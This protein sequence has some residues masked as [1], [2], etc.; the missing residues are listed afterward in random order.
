MAL[1]FIPSYFNLLSSRHFEPDKATMLRSIVVMM[2]TAGV[3]YALDRAGSAPKAAAP[4]QQPSWW[5]R[6]LAFPMALPV[7]VFALVFLLA[8]LTSITPWVSLWGSYQRLQGTYTNLSYIA[9]AVMVVL[10]LRRREQL[11]RL[12]A[13]GVLGALPAVGYGLI[14]HS[15]HDPLPWRGDV[16]SRVAS[17]MGNSIFVAAYL[18]LILPLACYLALAGF[19]A[20]RRDSAS[21]RGGGAWGW[22][23]AYGLAIAGALLIA[24]ASICFGAVVRVP[25]LRYWWVYPGALLV[26]LALFVLPTLGI[27]RADRLRT[28]LVWPGIAAVGY[29]L[30]LG[31]MF[32]LGQGGGDQQVAASAGRGGTEWWIY[33]VLGVLFVLGSYALFYTLPR[34][35]ESSRVLSLMQ[36]VG[37]TA[38]AV[39]V[40]M[41]IIFTQSRGPWIG[42]M[43]GMFVFFTA[44]IV[45]AW[46]RARRENPARVALWRGLLVAEIAVTVLGGGFLV[47]FNLS[48]APIFEPLRT[49]P[50]IGRMGRLLETDEGTGL[51]RRLIWSGDEHAGGAVALITSDP[52]R[53]VIGWGPES[54]FVAYNRFYPP[55]LANIEARGASPDRSHEAYLDELVTKGV[56]GLASYLFV[57]ISVFTL[58]IALIRRVD[59]WHAQALVSACLSIIVAHCVEGLTGIPIVSSLMLFWIA[60]ATIVCV[61][62]LYGQVRFGAQ[63]EPEPAP[64]PAPAAKQQGG[65]SRRGAA[66]RGAAQRGPSQRRDE[67]AGLGWLIYTLVFAVGIAVVWF[68]NIDNVYADMRFQQ[69]QQYTE[70]S[71]AGL[72]QQIAGAEFYL[73]AIRMEPNQDFYYLSLGRTLMSIADIQRQ[74]SGTLGAVKQDAQL[75]DLL[76]AESAPAMLAQMQPLVAMSYAQAVL[77]QAYKINPLNKDHSANLGR[78]HAYWYS[79]MD[80]DPAQLDEALQWYQNSNAKAP[81]DVVILNEYAGTVAL[82]GSYSESKGD[83]AAAQQAY[84]QAEQLLTHSKELDQKYPDTDIRLADLLRIQGRTAEALDRYIA[85]IAS[86]PHAL[87]AEYNAVI[88]SVQDDKAQLGRLRDAYEQALAKTPDDATLTEIIGRIAVPQGDMARATS[89]FELL[90]NLEPQNPEAYR[91]LVVV[92]SDT[93]QYSRAADQAASWAKMLQAQGDTQQAQQIQG[94]ESYFR[95]LAGG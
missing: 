57:L 55:A 59:D 71:N 86:S 75:R 73:D 95:N 26:C 67:S 85:I 87:D 64:E 17:T 33:L 12:L 83:A 35:G 28:S 9:L 61:G 29:A 77:D 69:G 32:M 38:V 51:V 66:Q 22:A 80:Q 79:R 18:I 50:Y 48:N 92:L 44:L 62:L 76:Q 81:Q 11:E 70:G 30:W 19:R 39:L 94:L 4:P 46:G 54:M 34:L 72:Q 14:Q 74:T 78:L 25:D 56:L 23:A 43:A 91:N 3:V 45:I 58:G 89:A 24:Y 68:T 90:V 41:T 13:V 49:M 20:A 5:R 15:E 40:G 16:I 27:H 37:M 84:A 8:T 31:L 47:A 2:I 6:V 93:M 65:R 88:A 53:M 63:P 21:E 36:G 52:L 82:K 60:I 7:L 1:V 10:F 42:A